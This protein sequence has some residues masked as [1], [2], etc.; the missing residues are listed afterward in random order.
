MTQYRK[1]VLCPSGTG[2][3]SIWANRISS[4]LKSIPLLC[5]YIGIILEI[6]RS[7][8]HFFSWFLKYLYKGWARGRKTITGEE[9]IKDLFIGTVFWT[10]VLLLIIWSPRLWF[11]FVFWL[12]LIDTCNILW[13]NM[14]ITYLWLYTKS[15]RGRQTWPSPQNY[16][17]VHV[18]SILVS[19]LS[20]SPAPWYHQ[21]SSRGP[22]FILGECFMYAFSGSSHPH[23]K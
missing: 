13:M 8:W 6:Y 1:V 4:V 18:V 12:F 7:C 23:S 5:P 14:E 15:T 16:P 22:M 11:C 19:L 9:K 3:D 20:S 2:W 17:T 10:S 21:S